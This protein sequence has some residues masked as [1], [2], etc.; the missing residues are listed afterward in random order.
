M[1][2]Q[3]LTDPLVVW[4]GIGLVILVMVAEKFPKIL[5]PLGDGIAEWQRDRRA[6][7]A[8][9]DDADLAEKDR[10]IAN[11]R[12]EL[13]CAKRSHAAT[14]REWHEHE[15]RWREEKRV[16]DAWDYAAQKALIGHEPPFDMAPDYMTPDPPKE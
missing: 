5:G 13:A 11:L 12:G 8:A 3:A 14:R 15:R 9:K 1:E 2:A 10:V 6:A 16:H 7:R 4:V